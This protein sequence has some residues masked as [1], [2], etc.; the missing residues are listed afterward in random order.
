MQ[1][2]IMVL[3]W[4]CLAMAAGC[5]W[6]FRGDVGPYNHSFTRCGF[7]QFEAVLGAQDPYAGLPGNLLFNEIR[8]S[9]TYVHVSGPFRGFARKTR[10]LWLDIARDP[11]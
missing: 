8:N 9:R 7:V 2:G 4:G 3:G 5:R 1:R 11:V 10:R 6:E